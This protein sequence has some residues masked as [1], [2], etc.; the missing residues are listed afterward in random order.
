MNMFVHLLP[1]VSRHVL[2]IMRHAEDEELKDAAG[3]V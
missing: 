3:T 2:G 1:C